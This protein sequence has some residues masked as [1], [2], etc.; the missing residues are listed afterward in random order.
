MESKWQP[1]I[2]DHVWHVAEYLT[3]ASGMRKRGL[4]GFRPYGLEVVESEITSILDNG[5]FT[6]LGVATSERIGNIEATDIFKWSQD[7]L[8]KIVFLDCKSAAEMAQL[9]IRDMEHGNIG[10]VYENKPMYKNW[11]HLANTDK[12]PV[13]KSKKYVHV[14]PDGW[15]MDVYNEWLKGLSA[16]LHLANTDKTPVLKSK[17]YVHVFPDGWDMDVY[18]EWLK[19]LSA[20]Q[21]AEKCGLNTSTFAV[22]ARR[23]AKERGDTKI[24]APTSSRPKRVLP[25]NFNDV[26]DEYRQGKISQAD[27]ARKCAMWSS[28]FKYWFE[29]IQKKRDAL[30]IEDE[31]PEPPEYEPEHVDDI[32]LGHHNFQKKQHEVTE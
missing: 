13:L 30:G 7:D 31:E 11:L 1:N 6:A 16:R 26:C 22:H 29:K 20:R 32:D 21:A 23:L 8:N 17:K 4:K 15:D 28:T 5:T 24:A 3:T 2:G 10:N 12:T 14:F 27:A 9:R 18:N 19:G 25:D